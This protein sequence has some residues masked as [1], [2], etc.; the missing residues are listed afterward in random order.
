[1]ASS[2]ETTLKSSSWGILGTLWWL[3]VVGGVLVPLAGADARRRR[4]PPRPRR[5][6]ACHSVISHRGS[7]YGEKRAVLDASTG[8]PRC[9]GDGLQRKRGRT[10]EGLTVHCTP[11]F[12]ASRSSSREGVARARA[13]LDRK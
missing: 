5:H 12:Q 10:S 9:R 6:D 13:P 1:M 7:E 2:Q 8:I 4:A 3:V 11:A